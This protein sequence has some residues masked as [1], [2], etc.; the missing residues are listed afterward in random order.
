M[1]ITIVADD[2]LVIVDGVSAYGV[3]LS[4]LDPTVHAVQWD[5]AR[6]D[7]EYRA[8]PDTG[9]RKMNFC[10]VDETPYLVYVERHAIRL[11]FLEAEEAASKAAQIAE[12]EKANAA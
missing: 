7:I 5:G 1:R 10:I 12:R 11:A 9:D 4:G 2:N 3:D 6:G 8:D